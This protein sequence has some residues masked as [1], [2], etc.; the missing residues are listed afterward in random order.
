MEYECHIIRVDVV[1]SICS[2]L[3]QFKTAAVGYCGDIQCEALRGD[4]VHCAIDCD[5]TEEQVEAFEHHNCDE[6]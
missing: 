6:Y 3:G 5:E 2:C 1:T 4:I